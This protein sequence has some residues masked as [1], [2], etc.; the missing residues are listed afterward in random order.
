MAPSIFSGSESHERFSRPSAVSTQAALGSLGPQEFFSA[1]GL[2]TPGV[3][4]FYFFSHT[5]DFPFPIPVS[6]GN[7]HTWEHCCPLDVST[8][9]PRHFQSAAG[10]RDCQNHYSKRL[11]HW[12]FGLCMFQEGSS[13]HNIKN[14]KENPNILKKYFTL[15]HAILLRPS[16]YNLLIFPGTAVM[17]PA[18]VQVIV[19][20]S[21]PWLSSIMTF[22][23]HCIWCL[24]SGRETTLEQPVFKGEQVTWMKILQH[25][26]MAFT[27]YYD[28][29]TNKHLF[30]AP[31]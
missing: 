25:I 28:S 21:S 7:Q 19:M 15:I 30:M 11:L 10:S 26:Q 3:Q 1:Q 12:H 18:D 5:P 14:F 6:C 20:K 8:D 13:L 2:A 22:I 9:T 4:P 23:N 24:P 29:G 16:I 17:R 27:L 31:I